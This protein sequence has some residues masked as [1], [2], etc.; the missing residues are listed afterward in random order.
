MT[1]SLMISM[2]DRA[3]TGNDLLSILDTLTEDVSVENDTQPT[4]EAIEF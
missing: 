1:T 4:L 3:N 2:L